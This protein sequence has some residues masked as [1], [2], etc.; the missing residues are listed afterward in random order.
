MIDEVHINKISSSVSNRLMNKLSAL[1]MKT[2][3]DIKTLPVDDFEST[4]SVGAKT[5]AE[6]IELKELLEKDPESLVSASPLQGSLEFETPLEIADIEIDLLKDS[7]GNKLRNIL[8]KLNC[9]TIHDVIQVSPEDF[10]AQDSVGK[11]TIEDFGNLL[12]LIYKVPELLKEETLKYSPK[13]I[14]EPPLSDDFFYN[15]ERIIT[16]YFSELNDS[17]A[18][19]IIA[20]R[21]GLLGDSQYTLEEIGLFYEVT[22]ERIRQI[23]E[24]QFGRIRD[25]LN[26]ETIKKP[27]VSVN[28]EITT[29]FILLNEGFKNVDFVSEED[30]IKEVKN[31]LEIDNVKD[32]SLFYFVFELLGFMYSRYEEVGYFFSTSTFNNNEFHSICNSITV[33]LQQVVK[34]IKLFDLVIKLKKGKI[35]TSKSI[36]EHAI[37]LIPYI[38]RLI[39][40]DEAYYQISIFKLTSLKDMA[41]RILSEKQEEMHSNEI[42]RE[43]QHRLVTRGKSSRETDRSMKG[44]MVIDDRFKP[45][46]RTGKWI[47]S[48]WNFNTQSIIELVVNAFHHHNQPCSAKMIVEYISSIRDDIRPESVPSILLQHKQKF[49]RVDRG[50]YILREW[51]PSYPSAKDVGEESDS[52]STELFYTYLLEIYQ[53]STKSELLLKELQE[54]LEIY[55][56]FWSESYCHVRFNKCPFLIKEKRGIKN[57]YSYDYEAT[58]PGKTK[59]VKKLESL[60]KKIFEE[61]ESSHHKELPLRDVV[62]ALVDKGE[63]RANVYGIINKYPELFTKENKDGIVH[64][65]KRGERQEKDSTVDMNQVHIANIKQGEGKKIEFKSTLRWDL[66]RNEVNKELEIMVIKAIASFL[67]TE[68]GNL[69]IGVDDDS[70]ILGIDNDIHTLKKKNDDG[71]ILQLNQIISQFLGKGVFA[72]I[73]HSIISIEKKNIISVVVKK[74]NSPVYI[75]NGKEKIFVIRAAASVQVL[76]IED[77]ANYIK[78]HWK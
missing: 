15:V 52:I 26:G 72:S 58:F 57:Y 62:T 29:V 55:D 67:N 69:Y 20:K 64:I 56:V 51:Q 28:P 48:E 25:L 1:G 12:N 3:G 8:E 18:Q 13:L 10:A 46:G 60:K 32:I 2:V 73:D 7:I 24:K 53:E 33:I 76:D 37:T 38:E 68:G 59:S 9:R 14:P 42:F 61:I 75:K 35:T 66:R 54:A 19:D 21:Y 22:R 45:I 63:I 40:D 6:F 44:Q 34:P 74:S 78:R 41:Y 49:L 5:L 4:R 23:E 39:F 70:N 31:I 43:I 30:A 77:A 36:I 50:L 11:K 65:S 16:S 17:K 47:L 71:I 27:F